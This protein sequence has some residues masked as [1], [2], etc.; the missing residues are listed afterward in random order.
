MG[1][2]VFYLHIRKGDEVFLDPDGS[3]LPDVE[4]ARVKAIE[5]I[6]DLL[7]AAIKRGDDDMLDEAIIITDQ[8]GQ[9]LMIIPYIEALPPRLRTALSS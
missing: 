2:P 1:M 4:A 3:N 5:G 9:E 7:A 6:R 8:A